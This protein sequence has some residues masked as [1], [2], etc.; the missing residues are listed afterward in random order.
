M[1][2][3]QLR[4]EPETK[5]LV[6]ESDLVGANR[7]PVD[8]RSRLVELARAGRWGGN[9]VTRV[10]VSFRD[11]AAGDYNAD[12]LAFVGLGCRAGGVERKTANFGTRE[13]F[14]IKS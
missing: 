2:E 13:D 9:E 12:A 11:V 7:F 8:V 5:T 4:W 6:Y 14:G 3:K 1:D 10:V